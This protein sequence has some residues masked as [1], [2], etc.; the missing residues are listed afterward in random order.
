MA[1]KSSSKHPKQVPRSDSFNF[2]K[3]SKLSE[4]KS[5]ALS[6]KYATDANAAT[7]LIMITLSTSTVSLKLAMMTIAAKCWAAI[8]LKCTTQ[9]AQM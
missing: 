2:E 3:R 7:G 9:C 6:L 8:P 5:R 1:N 4:F